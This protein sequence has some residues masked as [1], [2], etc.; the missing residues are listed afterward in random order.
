MPVRSTVPAENEVKT[1]FV[2]RFIVG[3]ALFSWEVRAATLF[4]LI[5]TNSGSGSASSK[6]PG[7]SANG[8]IQP[9]GSVL[10]LHLTDFSIPAPLR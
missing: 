5:A 9:G 1:V 8:I 3:L 10:D 6:R 4:L 2:D 7:N